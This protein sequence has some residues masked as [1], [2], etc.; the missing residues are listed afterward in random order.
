MRRKTNNRNDADWKNCKH[1]VSLFTGKICKN[2]EAFKFDMKGNK[3]SKYDTLVRVEEKYWDRDR[4][5]RIRITYEPCEYAFK[6]KKPRSGW[7]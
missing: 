6:R 2:K 7:N 3:I 1:C 5:S 4:K